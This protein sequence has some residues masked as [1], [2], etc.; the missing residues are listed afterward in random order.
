MRIRLKL[1]RKPI[2]GW[3][4]ISPRVS[5]WTGGRYLVSRWKG[6]W[7]CSEVGRPIYNAMNTSVAEY[8]REWMDKRTNQLAWMN[9]TMW[10]I[11]NK[12]SSYNCS[13]AILLWWYNCSDHLS[14]VSIS[15]RGKQ[16]AFL[17]KQANKQNNQPLSTNNL[18]KTA[19]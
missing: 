5:E 6:Q 17:K 2:W 18:R 10:T 19:W 16:H 7:T 8:M 4:Q 1:A 11:L 12:V 14:W 3:G 13:I 15:A 9:G